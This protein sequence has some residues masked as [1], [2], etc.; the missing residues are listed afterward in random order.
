MHNALRRLRKRWFDA[1][2]AL[3]G[4][5]VIAVVFLVI[6]PR[7][8]DYGEVWRFVRG[9]S[10]PWLVVIIGAA[11]I[12]VITFAPP[13]MAALPG[14]RF[15]PALAV[16]LASTA[17]TYVAPGGP[18]LGMTLSFAM[19]RGWGFCGRAVTVAVTVTAVWNQFVTFGMSALSLG[20]LTLSGGRQPLL[21]TAALIGF[22]V[23]LGSVG[24]FAV[25]LS[26]ARQARTAGDLMARVATALLRLGRRGGVT[27][28]GESFVRFRA[29]TFDL[30]RR[31]W[32]VL[33]IATL[34]GHL[35]V[36]LVLIVTL[37]ALGVTGGEVSLA[38]SFAAWTLARVIAAIPITPGGFG[39]VELGLTSALVLF[40]GPTSEVVTAVLVYR[41][42]TVGPPLILGVIAGA[43]WRRHNPAALGETIE[44]T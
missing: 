38:E 31:R 2:I 23:F 12:N 7:I 17:S 40:G 4:V 43:T 29:D 1:V 37:R 39:T 19:L 6:L 35:T 25:V 20:L 9:V 5:A 16:T 15:R 22:L 41:F 21:Q 28:S 10:W 30:L 44:G 18:A 14:I 3:A 27:W 13:L 36:Y 11:A 33:T 42:L 26:S 34:L 24:G 32:H 8:A